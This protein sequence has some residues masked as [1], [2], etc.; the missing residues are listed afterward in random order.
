MLRSA[1][2]SL[3]ARA[4]GSSRS[5]RRAQGSTRSPASLLRAPLG[6]RVRRFERA[7]RAAHSRR[8][9]DAAMIGAAGCST[10]DCVA[11][12]LLSRIRSRAGRRACSPVVEN[13]A[14]V[15]FPADAGEQLGPRSPERA[16]TG[17]S[18]PGESTATMIND[19]CFSLLLHDL[20]VLTHS[21]IMSISM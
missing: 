21:D 19:K 9:Q 5:D 12:R 3:P 17:T 10:A 2:P 16:L 11:G 15:C 8:I 14:Q 18:A 7:I 20:A 4:H 1:H 13:E 6:V